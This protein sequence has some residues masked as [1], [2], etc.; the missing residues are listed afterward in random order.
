MSLQDFWPPSDIDHADSCLFTEAETAPDAVF[1]AVHQPMTLM[2]KNYQSDDEAVPQTEIQIFEEFVRKNPSSGTVVMPIIGD[3]AVGKSHMIRWI[4]AHFRVSGQAKGRHIVR[5]PKSASMKTVLGLILENLQG[6][7]YD[8]LKEDLKQAK[9][10][11]DS[12]QASLDLRSNLTGALVR[13]ASSLQVKAA[14]GALNAQ[15]QARISHAR[16]LPTFLNDTA[17]SLFLMDPD[18]KGDE[19][20]RALS[21]IVRPILHDSHDV[22]KKRD[23]QFYPE[24]LG[25]V[26]KLTQTDVATPGRPYFNRLVR[27]SE[28]RTAVDLLNELL[29]EALSG[30]INYS[31]DS[32]PDLFK[33]VRAGLLSEGRELILLVEDFA[34]LGGI[35]QQLLDAVTDPALGSQ[36]EQKYCVMRT[37]I[38]VTEGR[39]DEATVLTRAGASW[40]IQ[41]QPFGS[42]SEALYVF[43]NMVGG[44][45][46]AARHGVAELKKQFQARDGDEARF[47]NFLDEHG[48]ELSESE[49]GT[50]DSFGYSPDGNYP[51]FPFNQ[52]A[53]H[54]IMERKLKV[55]G[56]YQFKPRAL[57]R[58]IRDTVMNYR[59]KWLEGEFPPKGYEQFTRNKLGSEVDMFLN[60][61]NNPDRIAVLLG[62][63]GDCP[64]TLSKAAEVPAEQYDAFGLQRPNWGNIKPVPPESPPGRTP[65][66]G[67]FPPEPPTPMEPGN[68]TTWKACL[69][70]W[71]VNHKIG[72]REANEIRKW[73]AAGV[74]SYLDK[75]SLLVRNFGGNLSKAIYLPF[76]RTGNPDD[77]ARVRLVTAT[78]GELGNAML[79]PRFFL[80][81]NAI[82]Q[83]NERRNWAYEGGEV[84]CARYVNFVQRM[85]AE[86]DSQIRERGSETLAKES[87]APLVHSLMLGARILNLDKASSQTFEGM[88]EALLDP[89]P[90]VDTT[91]RGPVNRWESLKQGAAKSRHEMRKLLLDHI[92]A[93]QGGADKEHAVDAAVL[94]PALKQLKQQDWK[95][96]QW[97]DDRWRRNLMVSAEHISS[98]R[99]H[100]PKILDDEIAE[101]AKWVAQVQALLGNSFNFDE[102]VNTMRDTITKAVHSGAFRCGGNDDPQPLRALITKVKGMA[103]KSCFDQAKI[104]TEKQ[105]DFGK[106]LAAIGQLETGIMVE[107]RNLIEAFEAFLSET[108]KVTKDRLVGAPNP[109]ESIKELEAN[110]TAVQT[111]WIEIN[112]QISA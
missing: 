68:L 80:A 33:K 51:L 40:R 107:T 27:E 98:L 36:G 42:E 86:L 23:N 21:R 37:A 112:N 109:Q 87:I 71:R 84:D 5:I 13:L 99:N 46:N 55:N 35:Q 78:E 26:H 12:Y 7:E 104:A 25:F 15:D 101:A 45:L 72:Q 85:A 75:D 10:P 29:D 89:G 63:W 94:I 49:R 93:R 43:T 44:Y 38:A 103:V 4:D 3:S 16:G 91:P 82:V 22:D 79:G 90:P 2:R 50:L 34:M 88:I 59:D 60:G 41:S 67:H 39:L 58:V 102:V 97:E 11:K 81:I 18:S 64:E 54:Q 74:E 77:N 6:P 62:Y 66:A 53:I 31:G 108:G 56:R 106:Q 17:I 92:A 83:F 95:L 19:D 48:G 70:E 52:K 96:G 20:E 105:S 47:T 65:P 111:N 32:L 100:L 28:R 69:E 110:L 9:L 14:S 57:N 73:I 1:L 8:Q 76:A 24:D 30:L 61:T